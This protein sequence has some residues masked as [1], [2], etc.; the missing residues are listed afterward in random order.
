MPTIKE[1]LNLAKKYGGELPF[2]VN[3]YG[4]EF[5]NDIDSPKR[6]YF[7][8]AEGGKSGFNALLGGSR[9]PTGTYWYLGRAGAYRSSTID[10][11]D[12]PQN[13][14]YVDIG[15]DPTRLFVRPYDKSWGFSCRCIQD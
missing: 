4:G 7:E 3:R 10:D 13:P 11:D 2:T 14:F 6:A 5:L 15:R 1:W 8:L 12:P 9:E